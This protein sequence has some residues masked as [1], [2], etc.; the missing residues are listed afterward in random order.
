MTKTWSNFEFHCH[1][2]QKAI[3]ISHL[4]SC[5]N[6]QFFLTFLFV[7]HI[8]ESFPNTA[9]IP[10]FQYTWD[11]TS[12]LYQ[13][14]LDSDISKP[15]LNAN[16]ILALIPSLPAPANVCTARQTVIPLAQVLQAHCSL[17]LEGCAPRPLTGFC[18]LPKF[19]SA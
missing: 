15:S 5:H 19:V 14:L 18:L 16:S 7:L 9:Q 6:Y 3:A 12:I 11:M 1:H 17:C 8:S 4:S 13:D 2:L 10:W